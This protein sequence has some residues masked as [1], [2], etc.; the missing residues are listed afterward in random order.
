MCAIIGTMSRRPNVHY[1]Q[2]HLK[3]EATQL[4]RAILP[5]A[6]TN[7]TSRNSESYKEVI[8]YCFRKQFLATQKE[9]EES[10]YRIQSLNQ[11]ASTAA[12]R[13][14]RNQVTKINEDE[15]AHNDKDADKNDVNETTQEMK[16]MKDHDD[17]VESFED[18]DEEEHTES[19]E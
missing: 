19:Y 4:Y 5:V 17:D 6:L 15:Q 10:K 16:M 13:K 9:E 2:C 7:E 3:N 12:Q 1:N 8:C 18:D 14:R 11:K